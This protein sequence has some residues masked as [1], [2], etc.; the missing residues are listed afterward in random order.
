LFEA[1]YNFVKTINTLSAKGQQIRF[2]ADM[3]NEE[4]ES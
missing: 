1:P 4:V 3:S 2:R